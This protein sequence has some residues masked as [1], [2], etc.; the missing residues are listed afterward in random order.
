M[1]GGAD[2]LAV[3]R[4]ATR[5]FIEDDPSLIT[6]TPQSRGKVASG[7][8]DTVPG[9]PRPPQ[10]FKLIYQAAKGEP[11]RTTDGSVAKQDVVIV[12]LHDAEIEHGDTFVWPP[13]SGNKWV[14]TGIHPHNGYEVKADA[15]AYGKHHVP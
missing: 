7:A 14:V 9:P 11:D 8:Y 6:L 15:V 2:S 3:N 13:A 12:G 4:V 1:L 5:M 10:E